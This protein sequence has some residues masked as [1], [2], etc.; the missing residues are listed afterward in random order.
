MWLTYSESV[1]GSTLVTKGSILGRLVTMSAVGGVLAAAI[2][3]P[4]VG[5]VGLVVKTGATKFENL[6]TS[7]LGQVPQRSELLDSD[8]HPLA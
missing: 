2:A 4:V 1:F 8:G 5:S 3:L 7:A 6:S